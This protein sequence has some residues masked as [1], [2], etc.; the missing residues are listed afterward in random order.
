MGINVLYLHVLC[1]FMSTHWPAQ[2]SMTQF[3]I[4]KNLV[5]LLTWYWV[6]KVMD[7]FPQFQSNPTP[8]KVIFALCQVLQWMG[9]IQTHIPCDCGFFFFICISHQCVDSCS[10]FN[11]DDLTQEWFVLFEFYFSI[12]WPSQSVTG[13]SFLLL[14]FVHFRHSRHEALWLWSNRD[15][16]AVARSIKV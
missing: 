6:S 8:S 13:L 12:I 4:C 1:G 9:N 2:D 16:L 15:F 3:R 10:F 7:F 11:L 5:I 14:G